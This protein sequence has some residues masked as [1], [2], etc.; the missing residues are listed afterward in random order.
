MTSKWLL[1]AAHAL[2]L[3]GLATIVAVAADTPSFVA[4][5]SDHCRQL[6]SAVAMQFPGYQPVF[7]HVYGLRVSGYENLCFVT[8]GDGLQQ[9][10]LVMQERRILA[11]LESAGQPQ[12]VQS[13]A[14]EDLNNDRLPEVIAVLNR[15]APNG[16]WYTENQVYWSRIDQ[17]QLRWRL[18][19]QAD[20]QQL[21]FE[22]PGDLELY[23]EAQHAQLQDRKQAVLELNGRFVE[24]GGYLYFQPR[25]QDVDGFYE[26]VG[27]PPRG[28]WGYSELLRQD[29]KIKARLIK[30]ETHQG[31]TFRYIEVLDFRLP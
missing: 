31:R 19:P 30:S 15:Q 13:L 16:E 9:R 4:P 14:F 2:W 8:L 17:A 11:R 22:Q 1:N 20:A 3:T 7:E 12:T 25:P 6:S 10:F 5:S 28:G 23:L 29:S 24:D 21:H 26:V 18:D 27:L